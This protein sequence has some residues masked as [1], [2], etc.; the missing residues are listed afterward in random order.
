VAQGERTGP[1][2]IGAR[3]AFVLAAC[4]LSVGAALALAPRS[5]AAGL[6][7]TPKAGQVF[8]HGVLTLTYSGR[9]VRMSPATCHLDTPSYHVLDVG[10]GN[11]TN[12]RAVRAFLQF[13]VASRHATT[14]RMARLSFG[15]G[16]TLA[17]TASI[18]RIHLAANHLRGTFTATTDTGHK[19]VSG[20]WTCK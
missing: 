9:T 12:V 4:C 11:T 3:G 16:G 2:A 15:L 10:A 13:A 1:S 6:P 14:A 7:C 8:C 19:A 18:I 17:N 20:S 5:A